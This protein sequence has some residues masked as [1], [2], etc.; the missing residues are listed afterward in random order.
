MKTTKRIMAS[1]LA[2][3]LT[4]GCAVPAFAADYFDDYA[5]MT[6][7]VQA[8]AIVKGISDPLKEGT[9]FADDPT[10]E[11]K[12]KEYAEFIDA[13]YDPDFDPHGIIKFISVFKL[14][15]YKYDEY[16]ITGHA[17]ISK[18]YITE[19]F[20]EQAKIVMTQEDY[21]DLTANPGRYELYYIDGDAVLY[22]DGLVYGLENRPDV[23]QGDVFVE[24]TVAQACEILKKLDKVFFAIN[25]RNEALQQIEDFMTEYGYWNIVEDEVKL[26]PSYDKNF[27]YNCAS[28]SDTY[29]IQ[30]GSGYVY[31]RDFCERNSGDEDTIVFD[32]D[33]S[34]T[35]FTLYRDG[36]DLYILDVANET[37]VFVD[38]YFE[39]PLNRV[40]NIQFS[41]DITLGYT[42]IIKLVNKIKGTPEDDEIN[43]YLESTVI[44]GEKGS[45]TITAEGGDEY[46]IH[47]GSG[48][49]NVTVSNGNDIIVAEDGNDNITIS[50]ERNRLFTADDPGYNVIL[51]GKGDDVITLDGNNIV[52]AGEGDDTINSGFGDDVFVYY[53]GDGNDTITDSI[54]AWSNGGTDVVY[55]ADLNPED[56]YVRRDSGFTF[57]V[58]G[59]KKGSVHIPGV[60]Q[61]GASKYREPIEYVVFKDGTVWN[62]HDYLDRSR[63]VEDTSEF[64][65]KDSIGYFIVG[66]DGDDKY[67]TS[68]GDDVITPG[69]GNDFVNAGGGTDTLIFRRGDGHD[70]FN[71]SNG[72]SY[73]PGG[74]DTV[75]FEDINSDEVYIARFGNTITIKVKDSEDAVELPGI[76]QS[77]FSGPLHPIEK[78]KF[79]NGVEWTF[80]EM[81]D[82]AVVEAT[83]GDDSFIVPDE[84]HYI[85]CGKG[86]DYI[87]GK[88]YDDTYYFELGD[89]HDVIEDQSIWGRSYDVIQFGKSIS[90]DMLCVKVDGNNYIISIPITDDSLS[91]TKGQIERFD[92]SHGTSLTEDEILAKASEHHYSEKPQCRWKKKCDIFAAEFCFVCSDCGAKVSYAAEVS[93]EKGAGDVTIYTAKATIGGKEYTDTYKYSPSSYKS[94]DLTFE[95]GRNAVKLTWTEILEAEKYAVCG[96]AGGK[97]QMLAKGDGTSYVLKNL[98]AGTNYKVAVAVMVNGEWKMDASKAITVTPLEETTKY[99]AV[100]NIEYN[101][102]YHQFKIK[103]TKAKGA[104]EYGVA[105]KQG[106]KWKVYSYTKDTIFTSPKLK[107]GT[108]VEMVI[109]AKVNGKWDTSNLNARAFSVTVK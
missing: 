104:T 56:V 67:Y 39:N 50:R 28:G 32:Y 86:N 101:V 18:E 52:V 91:L 68:G 14:I 16:K 33:T 27:I 97:W 20:D 77:G 40:E 15:K 25:T 11:G 60:Y 108:K 76:Y 64:T 34:D 8:L 5:A 22:R 29:K 65:G 55:F 7:T 51:S 38:D 95:K 2:L 90:P 75:L 61:N 35:H 98:K 6:D 42:D 13:V 57:Y 82:M 53:Y 62:L 100:E 24:I 89:G 73:P 9:N 105:V 31:I 80:L 81:L 19:N 92:F 43:G 59:D 94:P 99:P 45:D 69:K 23:L 71:E 10:L 54:N 48:N 58:K 88:E 26:T 107:A 49:N 66:T 12:A 103:W 44:W 74:E 21:E 102:Q 30:K 17:N 4:F 109:C 106:G 1:V 63:Y 70:I 79:A 37:L 87:R 93:S 47:A 85:I 78:A 84:N 72:G 46:Y 83:D 96:Y 41:P 36:G 3:T